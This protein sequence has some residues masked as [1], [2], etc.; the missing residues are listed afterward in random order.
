VI[1]ARVPVGPGFLV[2]GAVRGH[3]ADAESL[4]PKLDEF[5]PAA[6]ALGLSP[7]ESRGIREY[8]VLSESEPVV[9]LT[10]NEVAEVHGLVRYGEVRV[11]NPV[12]VRAM[13]W[14]RD[15]AVPVEAVDPSDVTYASLFAE[16]IGYVELV[17]RTLRERGLTR[18]PPT[19]PTADEYALAWS[20]RIAA[21]SGSA[22][23]ARARDEAA[24]AGA[25]G[26][27]ARSGRVALVVDRE[28]FD[29]VVAALSGPPPPVGATP[30]G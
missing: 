8:F 16:H 9:P 19:P 3:L 2:V 7:D 11:P 25:R 30:V 27:A 14:G 6:V 28:R 24:V 15:H 20:R 18:H 5:R 13:L 4:A 12:W 17:R 26:I 29:G 1:A 22:R 21:A 10:G 23:L